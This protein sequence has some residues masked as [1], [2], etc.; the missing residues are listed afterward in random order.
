MDPKLSEQMYI[1][2][3]F[4]LL[5]HTA[6]VFKTQVGGNHQN[7]KQIKRTVRQNNANQFVILTDRIFKLWNVLTDLAIL[8]FVTTIAR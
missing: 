8:F 3:D 6:L 5:F 1:Y 4:T 7:H 2:E